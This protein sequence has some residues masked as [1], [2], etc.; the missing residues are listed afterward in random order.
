[1]APAPT[2]LLREAPVLE[3][4]QILWRLVQTMV[5]TW[6]SPLRKRA[7]PPSP[8]GSRRRQ[9][10]VRSRQQV[11]YQFGHVAFDVIADTTGLDWPA[12]SSRSQSS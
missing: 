9:C 7:L 1:M 5:M 6:A 12:G 11:R 8:L 4:M 2:Q 10:S 3:I